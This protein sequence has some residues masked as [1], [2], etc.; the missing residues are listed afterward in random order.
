[1]TNLLSLVRSF[2]LNWNILANNVLVV[3]GVSLTSSDM[4][5]SDPSG[6]DGEA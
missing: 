1:M 2:L 3:L 4:L 5:I 6:S